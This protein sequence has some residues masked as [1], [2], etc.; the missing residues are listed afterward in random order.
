MGHIITYQE[1]VFQH[2]AALELWSVKVSRKLIVFRVIM[3]LNQGGGHIQNQIRQLRKGCYL[4]YQLG[5]G[6]SQQKYDENRPTPIFRD[7]S[8]LPLKM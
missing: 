5:K 2:A 8:I 4:G 7:F 1:I 6:T 3:G